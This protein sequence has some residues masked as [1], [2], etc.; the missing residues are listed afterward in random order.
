MLVERFIKGKSF[1]DVIIEIIRS[2]HLTGEQRK[3][4]F[5]IGKLLAQIHSLNITMGDCK[6]ENFIAGEDGKIYVLDLEQGERLGDKVWDVAEFLYFSGHYVTTAS[7]CLQQFVKDFAD[8]YSSMGN[9]DVLREAAGLRYTKVF[10]PWTTMPVI[11]CISTVLKS[12][13]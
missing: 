11:Q 3:R 5:G 9:I 8:G 13:N 1:L 2:D 7:A 6:P 12:I 4:A 10:L